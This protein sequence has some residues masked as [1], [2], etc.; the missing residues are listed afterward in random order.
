MTTTRKPF[1]D[2]EKTPIDFETKRELQPLNAYLLETPTE[3]KDTIDG[4]LNLNKDHKMSARLPLVCVKY[5]SMYQPPL[6]EKHLQLLRELLQAVVD[7]KIDTV[8]K[9]LDVYPD[10]LLVKP[11]QKLVIESQYTW[12][13]F[14]VEN[15]NALT[16]AAKRRQFK[17]LEILLHYVNKLQD[18]DLIMNTKADVLKKWPTYEHKGEKGKFDIPH[19]YVT[20]INRMISVFKKE[21]FPNGKK[22][23]AKLSD[24][25]EV[26][27][28]QF[29]DKILPEDSVTLD[30]SIK[31]ELFIYAAFKIYNDNCSEW[32]DRKKSAFCR[33]II[34]IL[35]SLIPPE[36]A[37]KWCENLVGVVGHGMVISPRA[38]SLKLNGGIDFYRSSRDSFSALGGE[39]FCGIL[40]ERDAGFLRLF[41]LLGGQNS[42]EQHWNQKTAALQKLCIVQT[43]G[44]S[45]KI[46]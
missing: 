8:K 29:L 45:L 35:Q 1:I 20:E 19:E 26:A 46:V 38:K 16:I 7:S 37:E 28:R 13:K 43:I 24:E 12:Q 31:P 3:L 30:N 41:H 42:L 22:I 25:T 14:N 17:M 44:H 36:E 27:L 15:E 6:K 23:G 39:Y 21:T 10:L 33:P 18:Q 11:K 32:Q 2:L 9:I 5:Y 4:Y 34:G 40:G